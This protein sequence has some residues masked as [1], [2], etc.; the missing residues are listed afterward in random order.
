MPVM[1]T[2]VL[3][4][5]DSGFARRQLVRALPA[6]WPVALTH[7]SSGE[8]ALA[9]IRAGRGDVLLLDLNMPGLDG[10]QVLERIRAAD[11]PTVVIVVSGDIQPG[12]RERVLAL[13]ALDFLRKPVDGPALRALLARYGL[14]GAG[15]AGTVPQRDPPAVDRL[16]GYRELA[17][18]AMG[19]AADRLARLLRSFVQMPVPRVS[20]PDPADL[21]MV[22]RE[23]AGDG[24]AWAVCQGFIGPGIAGEALLIFNASRFEDL[25]ALLTYDEQIDEA[26]R[27]ELVMDLSNVLVGACLQGLGEQLDLGLRQGYPVVL[28]RHVEVAEL[29]RRNRPRWGRTLAIE[30]GCTIERGAI[31]CELLLLFTEASLAALD[32]RLGV[33]LD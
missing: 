23:L 28:G 10:Y 5:D 18:V 26:A 16:D 2:S 30:L 25:A 4:C 11:L 1:P 20:R 12:A 6:D 31:R 8:E 22:I 24:D 17:N 33:L 14:L 27:I 19:R 9:A 3:I 32:A 13:G 7:A 15:A 21:H 29:L